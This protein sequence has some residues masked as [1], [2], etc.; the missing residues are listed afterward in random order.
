MDLYLGAPV[1]QDDG[2]ILGHLQGVAMDA[3]TRE[4]RT[5]IVE[6][7]RW[8]SAAVL[9][10]MGA[11]EGADLDAVTVALRDDEFDSLEPY[12]LVRNL[13]PAPSADNLEDPDDSGT[14]PVGAA[15]GV[16]S[17]GFTPILEEEPNLDADEWV[18]DRAT[19]LR[20]TDADLGHVRTVVVDDETRRMTALIGEE[21]LVF[22]E[23]YVIPFGWI[24]RCG[25]DTVL[26]S[27]SLAQIK[28][29][30]SP[31]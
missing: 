23:D 31:T 20:A 26:L 5:L 1:Q 13:A 27:V 24:A 7:E 12:S 19:L 6:G 15:V 17:I 30:Q 2:D 3:Q 16:E 14:P 9:M 21:G 28:E 4:L 29:A 22:P 11:V 8:D 18:I 10:P 25:A